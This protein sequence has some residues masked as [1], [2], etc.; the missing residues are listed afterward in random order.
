MVLVRPSTL[1]ILFFSLR[2]SYGLVESQKHMQARVRQWYPTTKR[3]RNS[4]EFLLGA[5]WTTLETDQRCLVSAW[6]RSALGAQN[7]RCC[8]YR[9]QCCRCPTAPPIGSYS[10][11]LG[12]QSKFHKK[13]YFQTM[14][15]KAHKMWN[16]RKCEVRSPGPATRAW[17][18][19]PVW[20]V[21][22]VSSRF[23]T[24]L[25]QTVCSNPLQVRHPGIF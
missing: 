8:R 15:Q 13:S 11:H 10:Q 3:N 17:K 4:A 18:K 7:T 21:L 20:E 1:F 22:R 9:S 14:F 25:S 12:K 2:A 23:F 16:T 24:I 6:S 5:P 19:V